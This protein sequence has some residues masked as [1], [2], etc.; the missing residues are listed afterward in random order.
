MEP[1]CNRTRSVR[2]VVG[3]GIRQRDLLGGCFE[4]NIVQE[5]EALSAAEEAAKE[6][7]DGDERG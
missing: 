7:E 4:S 2:T 6:G 5:A 1:G 3:R